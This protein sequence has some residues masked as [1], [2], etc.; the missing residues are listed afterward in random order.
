MRRKPQKEVGMKPIKYYEDAVNKKGIEIVLRD[1][2]LMSKT[3]RVEISYDFDYEDFAFID[4]RIV[5]GKYELPFGA[6]KN[7]RFREL[8][9][10]DTTTRPSKEQV[11]ASLVKQAVDHVINEMTARINKV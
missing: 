5:D 6:E 2:Q 7:L 3:P 1:A 9:R 8:Q 11:V 10:K 4:N